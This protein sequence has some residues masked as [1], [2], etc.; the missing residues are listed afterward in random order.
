MR[1]A[2]W[3]NRPYDICKQQSFRQACAHPRVLPEGLLSL[4]QAVGSDK[5]PLGPYDIKCMYLLKRKHV[6]HNKIYLRICYNA[7]ALSKYS[8]LYFIYT[9]LVYLAKIEQNF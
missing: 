3:E 9:T 5:T 7:V 2:F 8:I 6:V 4:S 1:A